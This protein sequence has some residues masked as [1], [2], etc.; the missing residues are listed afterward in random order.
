MSLIIV[1]FSIVLIFVFFWLTQIDLAK[2]ACLNSP[3]WSSRDWQETLSVEECNGLNENYT[4]NVFHYNS[5]ND[6]SYMIFNKD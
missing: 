1:C 3:E 4:M 5:E 6:F 2:L